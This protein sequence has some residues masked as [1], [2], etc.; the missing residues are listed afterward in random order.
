MPY[1]DNNGVRIH[2]HVEG[3]GAPLVLLH[4]L[5]GDLEG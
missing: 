2:Y 4:G 1:V 5:G 3:A